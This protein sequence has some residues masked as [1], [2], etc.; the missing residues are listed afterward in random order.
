[1]SGKGKLALV[2]SIG[3]LLV[4]A[5]ILESTRSY[6]TQAV[7]IGLNSWPGYDPLLLA[8]KLGFFE[9]HKVRVDLKT[10]SSTYDVIGALRAGELDGAGLTLDEAVVLHQSGVRLKVAF[11]MDYSLGGDKL[12]GQH[13][14]TSLGL[15]R[16]KRVGYEGTL[17]GEFL[18]HRALADKRISSREITLVEI[19]ASDWLEAFRSRS[20]DAL[21]AYILIE[22]NGANLLFSSKEIPLEIIDVMVFR[23]EVFEE[24]QQALVKLAGSWFKSLDYIEEDFSGSIA[25]LAELRNISPELYAAQQA[26]LVA[27][28]LRQNQEMFDLYSTDNI[29]MLSQIIID[30]MLSRGLITRRVNTDEFFTTEIINQIETSN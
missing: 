4:L 29:F 23:E 7:R 3:L 27:P 16:G 13:D 30:F 11:I 10:Y 17:T 26:E 15:I 2:S 22:E 8:D 9:D 12:I 14:I 18:L 28:G 20:I 1:M 6:Y 21:V 5:A 19:E 25:M 24:R